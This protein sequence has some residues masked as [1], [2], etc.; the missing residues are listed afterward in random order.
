MTQSSL[1]FMVVTGK[2][3]K[4]ACSPCSEKTQSGNVSQQGNITNVVPFSAKNE[5]SDQYREL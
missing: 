3:R 5:T 2:K 1:I 4:V